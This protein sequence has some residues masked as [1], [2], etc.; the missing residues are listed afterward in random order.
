[1]RPRS[2]LVGLAP[3]EN[4]V[5]V[6][7][8]EHALLIDSYGFVQNNSLESERA[9]AKPAGVYRIIV[10]GGSTVAGWGAS[11]NEATWPA[12]LERSL[13]TLLA[14]ARDSG[15]LLDYETVE[16][17]N[18]GVPGY[19][20]SQELT[21]FQTELIYMQP[22]LVIVFNGIN[23]AWNF[24]GFPADF[25]IDSYQRRVEDLVLGRYQPIPRI[26]VLPY[27]QRTAGAVIEQ[28]FPKSVVSDRRQLKFYQSAAAKLNADQLYISKIVQFKAIC[29][30]F[31]IPFVFVFQP[32][33]GV[34]HKSLTPEETA[35]QS[36]WFG[37]QYYPPSYEQYQSEL[38]AFY[39]PVQK[40]LAQQNEEHSQRNRALVI[41][42]TGLFDNVSDR[43]YADPRHYNDRGQRLLAEALT[44]LI[45]D[46]QN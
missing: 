31:G 37:S 45:V 27:F 39:G 3:D 8:E 21:R 28:A 35:L 11:N 6:F 17:I 46:M 10:S 40:W 43:V 25:A 42:M 22:D 5:P 44:N 16:V 18:A 20:I 9:F 12:M 15:L 2:K 14:E 34:G 41:D 19:D 36:T 30:K 24:S 26:V 13:Q 7:S 23:E 29:R 1:M 38:Q 4:G 32:I 33:M